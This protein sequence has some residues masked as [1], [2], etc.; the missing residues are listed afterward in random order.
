MCPLVRYISTMEIN[1]NLTVEYKEFTAL[2]PGMRI[3]LQHLT[4]EVEAGRKILST[5]IDED[6]G[7]W[8]NFTDG[9]AIYEDPFRMSHR[10]EIAIAVS[11]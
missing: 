7:C 1:T 9:T 8:V 3:A 2:R 6:G 10:S 5:H 11:A 4:G